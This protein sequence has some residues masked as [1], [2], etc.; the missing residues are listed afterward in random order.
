MKI[1]D[2]LGLYVVWTDLGCILGHSPLVNGTTVIMWLLC[3]GEVGLMRVRLSHPSF[4]R[5]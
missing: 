2:D 5:L 3:A 4:A 1:C